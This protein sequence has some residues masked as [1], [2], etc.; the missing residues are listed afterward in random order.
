MMLANVGDYDQREMAGPPF[1]TSAERVGSFF[2]GAGTVV[3]LDGAPALEDRHRA[4]G[5][6]WLNEEVYLITRER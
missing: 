5:A 1:S 4:K 6:T 3:R 2:A